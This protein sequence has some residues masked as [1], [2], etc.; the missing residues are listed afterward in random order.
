MRDLDKAIRNY[1]FLHPY[2]SMSAGILAVL[3]FHDS[4]GG[5]HCIH[6]HDG[7]GDPEKYPCPTVVGMANALGVEYC[8]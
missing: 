3:D 6:C 1:M 5:Q 2:G 7:Y 8:D 4:A